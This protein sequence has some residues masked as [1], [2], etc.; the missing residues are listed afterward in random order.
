MSRE[1]E[2]EKATQSLSIPERAGFKVGV[3]WAD[4]HPSVD[5]VKK[6]ICH[7]LKYTNIMLVEDMKNGVKW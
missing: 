7:A 3:E 5:T 6:I 2:I 1:E 4:Q